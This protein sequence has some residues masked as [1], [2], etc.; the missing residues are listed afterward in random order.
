MYNYGGKSR[1]LQKC[2]TSLQLLCIGNTYYSITMG[3]RQGS[4]APITALL[5]LTARPMLSSYQLGTL[6]G[7]FLIRRPTPEVTHQPL[8]LLV[9]MSAFNPLRLDP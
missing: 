6:V 8:L 4:Q 3:S 7:L 9:T 2:D 5:F 1:L